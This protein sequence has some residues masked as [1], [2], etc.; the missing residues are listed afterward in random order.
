MATNTEKMATKIEKL[1]G[2]LQGGLPG[3]Y[4][5]VEHGKPGLMPHIPAL[6]A[7]LA[8]D[9][10]GDEGMAG[11]FVPATSMAPAG[12]MPMVAAD[13]ARLE[14]LKERARGMAAGG[15]RI[16]LVKFTAREEVE[17]FGQ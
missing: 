6:W 4:H 15:T 11:F 7:F 12:W 10:D 8:V 14:A 9:A 5:K 3:R 16:R 2:N 13:E 1:S 17:V